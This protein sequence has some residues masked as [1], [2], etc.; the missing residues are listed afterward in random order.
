[1]RGFDCTLQMCCPYCLPAR[2]ACFE[3]RSQCALRCT[4]LPTI[5]PDAIWTFRRRVGSPYQDIHV[6]QTPHNVW[7]GLVVIKAD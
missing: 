3:V 4:A 6:L 5:E 1:M 2:E 7:K